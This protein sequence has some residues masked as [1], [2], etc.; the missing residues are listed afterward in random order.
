MI[1]LI[2]CSAFLQRIYFPL[3]YSALRHERSLGT[4]FAPDVYVWKQGLAVVPGDEFTERFGDH[5]LRIRG[6]NVEGKGLVRRCQMFTSLGVTRACTRAC[7]GTSDDRF[8]VNVQLAPEP[9]RE[10]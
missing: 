1:V 2:L 4:I 7:I 6:T 3:C 10:H 5:A 9:L 8:Y